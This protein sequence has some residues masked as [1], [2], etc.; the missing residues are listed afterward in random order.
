MVCGIIWADKV[1]PRGAE[2][3]AGCKELASDTTKI[4]YKKNTNRRPPSKAKPFEKISP[5]QKY[6]R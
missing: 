6:N 2:A 3:A 1:A 5:Y 4:T